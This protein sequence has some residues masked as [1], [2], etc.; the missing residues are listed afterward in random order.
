[1]PPAPG[2]PERFDT[3]YERNGTTNLLL[4]V[5]ASAG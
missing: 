2:Q 1:M 3:E 4:F 5:E